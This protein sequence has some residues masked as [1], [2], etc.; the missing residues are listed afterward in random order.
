MLFNVE[1]HESLFFPVPVWLFFPKN[2]TNH[3]YGNSSNVTLTQDPINFKFPINLETQWCSKWKL[4]PF[5]FPN[6]T[7]STKY[8]IQRQN[9]T[10]EYA[11]YEL[12][13]S[14]SFIIGDEFVP[15]MLKRRKTIKWNK[16]MI[17]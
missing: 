16:T 4:Q 3:T 14:K 6:H 11:Y 5:E 2:M 13:T 15:R 17:A 12:R 8:T 1:I 9:E 7:K 10:L